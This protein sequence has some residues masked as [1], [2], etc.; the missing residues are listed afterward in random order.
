[1]YVIRHIDLITHC[2]SSVSL[3]VPKR[4]KRPFSWV[5]PILDGPQLS[6]TG[7]RSYYTVT[8]NELKLPTNPNMLRTTWTNDLISLNRGR[9]WLIN[10]DD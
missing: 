7:K 2:D 1:M 8:P 5:L 6:N 10:F 3:S 9:S 4:L